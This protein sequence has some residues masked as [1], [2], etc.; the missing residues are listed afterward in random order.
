MKRYFV[1]GAGAGAVVLFGLGLFL[2]IRD[3]LE[4]IARPDV[5]PVAQLIAGVVAGIFFGLFVIRRFKDEF[6]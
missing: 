3:L 6:E 4:W 2:L 5:F 1:I